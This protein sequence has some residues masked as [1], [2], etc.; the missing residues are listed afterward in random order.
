MTFLNRTMLRMVA[1]VVAGVAITAIGVSLTVENISLER[2]T[3]ESHTIVY[4]TVLSS[5]SQ[6]EGGNI[7]TYSTIRVRESLKGNNGS[8]V[9]V[10]QLG[11]TVGEVGQEVSG[12]P[13]LHRNE[14]VVLFLVQWNNQLWIHSIVLGKF[15]VTSEDNTLVA[16]ND[17][18]N[19]GL[20][21]PVTH[22]AITQSNLKSNHIPLRNF[23]SEVRSFATK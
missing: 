16:Y 21:D 6:W 2:M 8:T 17:L 12:S 11:G 10:K 20:V 14:D 18:N 19:I 5:Y 22:E 3:N 15:T 13:K 9:L 4:G 7:Y 1:V 23:L